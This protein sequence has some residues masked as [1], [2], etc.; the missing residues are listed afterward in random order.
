[1]AGVAGVAGG[2][3]KGLSISAGPSPVCSFSA[4]FF[5]AL[6]PPPTHTRLVCLQLL[7]SSQP[8]RRCAFTRLNAH[9]FSAAPP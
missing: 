3:V 5:D 9:A 1:M 4:P 8:P 6:A 2:I 7:T